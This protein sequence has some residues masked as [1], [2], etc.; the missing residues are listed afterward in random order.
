M[1]IILINHY[2]GSPRHG[3]EF[4]PYYLAR[5]WRAVGHDV[6]IVAAAESH[7]RRKSPEMRGGRIVEE[8]ID[9]VRYV[10]VETPRY[11][12]NGIGRVMN[13]GTFVARV[14]NNRASIVGGQPP[15]AVIASSTYP[16]D[17]IPANAIARDANAALLFEVH[18]L[19]PLSPIE[20][21]AMSPGHPF[22]RVMQW[23]EDKAYRDADRV[24]SILPCTLDHMTGRGMAADKF[25]HIPNGVDGSEWT[26]GGAE[27]PTEHATVLENARRSGRL[28]VGYAGAH[29]IANAL[30]T[31][32]DAAA[33]LRRDPVTFVLVGQGP[34][35]AALERRAAELGLDNVHFLPAVAKASI[36]RLLAGFDVA[37]LTLR[38]EPLFRYGVSPNKLFDYMM[39]GRPVLNAVDAGN[40]IVAESRSGI[41]VRGE[42]STALAD[43]V[44]AF[45][46]MSADERDAMGV[47]GRKFVLEHHVYDVLA[48]SYMD[49]IADAVRRRKSRGI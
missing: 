38:S 5:A 49:V 40:D 35:K 37:C 11:S 7:V 34:E 19:W 15:D 3:M 6:T 20:L 16:L 24:V 2:A 28:I 39:A 48:Q 25:A 14:M 27:L 32:I 10:W 44:K 42:N 33:V 21:G 23:A 17:I 9:G 43:A 46:E 18:D 36:P 41:S 45:M 1:K 47:R 26:E 8:L 12:G 22:I 30:D 4:R 31:I 29:G 13:I